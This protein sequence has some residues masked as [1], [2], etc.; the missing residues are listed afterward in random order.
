MSI[1]R[2]EFLEKLPDGVSRSAFGR[3]EAVA[4]ENNARVKPGTTGFSI[5]A[6]NCAVWPGRE[7]TVAWLYPSPGERGWMRTR[8]F[9]FGSGTGGH[10][11]YQMPGQLRRF[12]ED[13]AD[14]FSTLAYT[15]DVSSTG[16]NAWAVTHAAAVQHID[17][18]CQRL[19]RVLK[20]L[21]ELQPEAE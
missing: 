21:G 19:D 17:F 2:P 20:E 6:R 1:E 11:Y 14:S 10:S 8:D 9:S 7:I 3:L 13:W 4:I 5:R 18:L 15:D 16:L 12:L